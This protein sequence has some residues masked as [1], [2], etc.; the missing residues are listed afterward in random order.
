MT[1]VTTDQ[2]KARIEAIAD[3]IPSITLL[4]GS[5]QSIAESSL[6]ALEVRPGPA[7]NERHGA[8][9]RLETRT[10]QLWLFVSEIINPEQYTDLLPATEACHPYLDS[11]PDYFKD[12]PQL[13]DANLAN[14]LVYGTG[15]M[16]DSGPVRTPYKGKTYTAVR[17]TFS[18]TTMRP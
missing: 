14:P 10:W 13:Q 1:L 15:L 16:E 9:G 3:A 4:T 2:V 12:R 17:F 18:V 7:T 6:P 5:E 11:I 8:T